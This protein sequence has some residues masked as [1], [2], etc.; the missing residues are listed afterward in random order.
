MPFSTRQSN[1]VRVCDV[2]VV[3]LGILIIPR[4]AMASMG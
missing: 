1:A 3:L 2:S 4:K